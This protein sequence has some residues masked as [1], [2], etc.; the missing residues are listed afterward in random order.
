MPTV[1]LTLFADA[2]DYENPEDFLADEMKV[3][4]LSSA[5]ALAEGTAAPHFG[6]TG[7]TDVSTNEVSG[8]NVPAGGFSLSSKTASGDPVL[9][10]CADLPQIAQHA[11]NPANVRYMVL[12]DNTHASKRAWAFADYGADQDLSQGPNDVRFTNGIYTKDST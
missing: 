11:S 9:V 4:F 3:A 10:D 5:A 12:Y 8:G 6:G 7:T 1:A 2:R